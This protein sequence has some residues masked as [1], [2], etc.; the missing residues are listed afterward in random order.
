MQSDLPP[1]AFTKETLQ[2]AFQWL[3]NQPEDMRATVHTPERL[4]SLYRQAMRLQDNDAPVSSKVF[5]DNLKNLATS[6]D[7]FSG[8]SP[9]SAS[10]APMPPL[11]AEA[12]P[13]APAR[14]ASSFHPQKTEVSQAPPPPSRASTLGSLDKTS[15]SCVDHVR[16]RLNLSS[17][18]EA[19]RLLIAL[20]FEK[21]SRL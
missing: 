9:A 19:I 12:A 4:V 16:K 5:V 21:I 1:E 3:Q 14:S 20:G 8:S 7:E 2:K 10:S 17:D 15:Q 13:T 6:L 18:Q 11:P